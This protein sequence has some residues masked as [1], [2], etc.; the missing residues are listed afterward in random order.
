MKQLQKKETN[1]TR[2]SNCIIIEPLKIQKDFSGNN[3][4]VSF[5]FCF[6]IKISFSPD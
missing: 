6:S 3:L 2:R 5:S 1:G 4:F